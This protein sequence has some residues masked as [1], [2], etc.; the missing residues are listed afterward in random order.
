[1]QAETIHQRNEA[2]SLIPRDPF[3]TSTLSS[4][5]SS[6]L[7]SIT[8]SDGVFLP[9]T[10]TVIQYS[11]EQKEALKQANI[12]DPCSLLIE[13]INNIKRFCF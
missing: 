12:E 13:G 3:Y 7:T 10:G 2:K 11:G 5:S 1:P 8:T 9:E 6:T 4:S